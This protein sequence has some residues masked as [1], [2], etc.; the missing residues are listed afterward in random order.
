MKERYKVFVYGTLRQ[1][2]TNHYLLTESVCLV[3]QCY[4]NGKLY[5]TG[6]G[7]PAMVSDETNQVLGELYEVTAKQLKQLDWLEDYHGHGEKNE[8]ERITQPIF[9]VEGEVEAFVYVYHVSKVTGLLEIA[10]GDWKSH[11]KRKISSEK[12][13]KLD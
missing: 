6:C 4:T 10:S 2:E 8:Y 13:K 11:Q 7:Y 1:G 3:S 5:D 12:D 9:S